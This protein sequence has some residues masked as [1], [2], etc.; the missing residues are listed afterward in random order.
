MPLARVYGQDAWWHQKELLKGSQSQGQ[1]HSTSKKQP[2]HSGIPK[3]MRLHV[4]IPAPVID[5]F[6][7]LK[8][9]PVFESKKWTETRPLRKRAQQNPTDDCL[10]P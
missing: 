1:E 7:A 9:L 5:S 2:R 10:S 8:H 3:D 6:P 4:H